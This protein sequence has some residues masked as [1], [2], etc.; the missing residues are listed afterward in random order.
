MAKRPAPRPISKA[1]FLD[2]PYIL[3]SAWRRGE[4]NANRK[5]I[6]RFPATGGGPDIKYRSYRTQPAFWLFLLVAAFVAYGPTFHALCSVLA[7]AGMSLLRLAIGIAS[8]CFAYVQAWTSIE[9]GLGR[10]RARFEEKKVAN[11]VRMATVQ[12]GVVVGCLVLVLPFILFGRWHVQ[13]ASTTGCRSDVAACPA[14]AQ[15]V[16]LGVIVIASVVLAALRS[17]PR[18]RSLQQCTA[19][20]LLCA[21]LWGL[22]APSELTEAMQGPYRHVFGVFALAL[23][24]VVV[25][26]RGLARWQFRSVTRGQAKLFQDGLRT[27]E[28][29]PRKRTDPVLTCRRVVAAALLGVAYRPFQLLLLPSLIAL[30]VPSHWLVAATALTLL[31]AW[32]LL[33]IGN[34]S[35]RWQEMVLSIRRWFLVGTPLAVSTTVII[36]AASRLAQVQYVTTILDAAPSGIVFVWIV[37]AYAALWWFEYAVNGEVATELLRI[38][39]TAEDVTNECVPFELN[40]AIKARIESTHRFVV[41]H[42]A[43]RFAILGWF[44]PRSK[45]DSHPIAAFHTF[46]FTEFFSAITPATGRKALYDLNRRLQMYFLWINLSLLAAAGAYAW[47]LGYGDRHMTVHAIATA[48]APLPGD[49]YAE[50]GRLLERTD[51]TDKPA[52]VVAASGGGTR[53]ALYTAATLQGLERLGQAENIVLVSGVSGGGVASA[54]FYSH[55]AAL[56]GNSTGNTGAWNTYRDRMMDPFIEDVLDGAAE[57]R[58]VS[59]Y[60]LGQLLAESFQRRLFDGV[61]GTLGANPDVALILNAAFVGHPQEDA[62]LLRG[63][64]PTQPTPDPSRCSQVHR[65]YSL[66][67]GGRLVFTNLAP[68]TELGRPDASLADVDFPYVVVRDPAIPLAAAAA[69]NANFPPVFPN[70]RVDVPAVAAPGVPVDPHCSQRSYYVTDGGATEN[71]GLISALYA[72]RSTLVSMA[73][74][75][76]LHLRTIH[77][78]A[79]EASATTYDYAPDRGIGAAMGGAKERLAGGLTEEL[80]EQICRLF[81]PSTPAG[82]E[83]RSPRFAVHYL[84]LP[85]VFRSRGG[86]G[87]HWMF[88]ETIEVSNPRRPEPPTGITGFFGELFHDSTV[89]RRLDKRELND[90]WSAL[91]DPATPFCDPAPGSW[92]DDQHAVHDWICGSAGEDGLAMDKQIEAWSALVETLTPSKQPESPQAGQ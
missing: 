56:V 14:W 43:G 80:L 15:L 22:I 64:F 6:Y 29:F 39:G 8:I 35:P 5:F 63:I 61:D 47:Y 48:A 69:L 91:Y 66:L 89:Y 92:S 83:C 19:Y 45:P 50:L 1:L 70:A 58:I 3:D 40:P 68:M 37:M 51:A 54:Y 76:R 41:P 13:H 24:A 2:L 30:I 16:L 42:G 18:T 65:P 90:L 25:C 53:A 31:L 44:A 9:G 46:G 57:W 4:F 12:T 36:V 62:R 79:V 55:R 10:A 88:P 28:L 11:R 74:D 7:D 32:F 84:P 26:A 73:P 86:F 33:T 38:L 23:G 75:A 87:T 27:T 49:R 52:I 60:P 81:E 78:V 77:V 85:L 34:L 59:E 71:L 20:A 82:E 72:L 21:V 17:S 67:S